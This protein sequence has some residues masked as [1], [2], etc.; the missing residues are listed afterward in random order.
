M[1][2]AIVTRHVHTF[3]FII[4]TKGGNRSRGFYV[5][6]VEWHMIVDIL[7]FNCGIWRHLKHSNI[8]EKGNNLL[9][10]CISNV[11]MITLKF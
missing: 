6:Y 9:I 10:F 11:V 5:I 2:G 8:F 7:I 1:S 4:N 3:M